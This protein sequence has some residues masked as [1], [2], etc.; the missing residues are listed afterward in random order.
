MIRVRVKLRTCRERWEV[1]CRSTEK[2]GEV[3]G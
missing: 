1:D 2:F 3:G